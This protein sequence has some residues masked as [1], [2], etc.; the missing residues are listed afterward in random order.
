MAKGDPSPTASRPLASERPLNHC[1][2]T[3]PGG[4]VRPETATDGGDMR[5]GSSKSGAIPHPEGRRERVEKALEAALFACRE[6]VMLEAI[7]ALVRV[8][9]KVL[10]GSP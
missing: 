6:G 9:Q 7:A 5:S 10:S 1:D 3:V 4:Q 2:S 8:A